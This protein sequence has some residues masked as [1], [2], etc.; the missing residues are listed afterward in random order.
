MPDNPAHG[1]KESAFSYWRGRPA[2]RTVRY[3]IVQ[4]EDPGAGSE[5]DLFDH[6]ADPNE[7]RDL[8]SEQSGTVESLRTRLAAAVSTRPRRRAGK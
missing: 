8:A 7:T 6:E 5:S 4:H 2:M 1:G 3:R